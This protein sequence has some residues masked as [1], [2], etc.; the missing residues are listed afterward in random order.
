LSQEATVLILGA[1]SALMTTLTERMPSLGFRCARAKTPTEA[2]GFA[3]DRNFRFG[4]ALIEPH[5]PALDLQQALHALRE[6]TSSPALT[7]L[8][9]GDPPNPETRERLRQ[10]GVRQSVWSPVSDHV[11]RFQI[12]AAFSRYGD[13]FLR[14]E[15]RAPVE[16]AARVQVGGRQKQASVYSLSAG[17]AFLETPRPSMPGAGVTLDLET[18]AGRV[19]TR[20]EVAYTNVPGNV[21]RASLPI[22]MAVRFHE[23]D[24]DGAQIVRQVVT[25]CA[26]R[27]RV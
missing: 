13:D 14:I 20:G 1:E 19:H 25:E 4:V 2:I 24:F 18:R 26:S 23:M 9:T 15:Q 22:G 21:S 27:L 11:L 5:F 7:F 8:A 10:A 12:N 16:C 17:G 3:N 6:G